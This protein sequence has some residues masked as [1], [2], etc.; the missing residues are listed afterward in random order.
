[1]AKKQKEKKKSAPANDVTP[2]VAANLAGVIYQAKLMNR[3]AK[4]NISEAE[5]VSDV[6][7]LWRKVQEE[8]SVGN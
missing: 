8:L 3:A 7:N 6:V 1:M 5:V 4:L 2:L